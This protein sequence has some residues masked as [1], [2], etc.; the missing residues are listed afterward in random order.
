M[1]FYLSYWFTVSRLPAIIPTFDLTWKLLWQILLGIRL[2][3]GSQVSLT[4]NWMRK[5]SKF[6][7]LSTGKMQEIMDNAIPVTTRIINGSY[8]LSFP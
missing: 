5:K 4:K 7:E 8:S 3:V 1:Q 2:F 6:G